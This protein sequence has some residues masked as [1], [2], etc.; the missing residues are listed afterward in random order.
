MQDYTD[1]PDEVRA[2]LRVGNRTKDSAAVLIYSVLSDEPMTLNDVIVAVW[3]KHEQVLKRSTAMASIATLRKE[4]A[5][6][7]TER[8]SYIIPA[9]EAEEVDDYTD[10]AA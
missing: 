5:V 1:L 7:R 2:Q 8:G 6:G 3:R 4:G 9:E 10:E